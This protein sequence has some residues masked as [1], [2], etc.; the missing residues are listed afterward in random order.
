MTEPIW[1]RNQFTYSISSPKSACTSF[2]MTSNCQ[3]YDSL[4][5]VPTITTPVN[6]L[7][8]SSTQ[9]SSIPFFSSLNRNL[10][11]QTVNTSSVGFDRYDISVEDNIYGSTSDYLNLIQALN[12][13]ADVELPNDS[14]AFAIGETVQMI[15]ATL[16]SKIFAP[17]LY[18]R[19]SD[20]ISAF[21]A[22][23]C[24]INCKQTCWLI[25]LHHYLYLITIN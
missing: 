16:T 23:S 25:Q 24:P 11:T 21:V 19:Y 7:Q 3:L 20:I 8:V 6:Q 14:G 10:A 4:T 2:L 22:S 17:Y 15:W 1:L 18:C 9:V 12:L 13:T 5:S